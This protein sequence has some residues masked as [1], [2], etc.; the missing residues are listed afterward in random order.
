MPWGSLVLVPGLPQ[1]QLRSVAR[2]TPDEL[3]AYFGTGSNGNFGS[4]ADTDALFVATRSGVASAFGSETKLTGVNGSDGMSTPSISADGNTLYYTWGE[5]PNHPATGT[6]RDIYVA[7]RTGSASEFGSGSAINI[8]VV[9]SEENYAYIASD[10]TLWYEAKPA[11][12]GT[13][14][15]I[16]SAPPAGSGAFATPSEFPLDAPMM[17]NTY[18]VVSSDLRHVYF[19]RGGLIY[20][21]SRGSAGD[22]FSSA[23]GIDELNNDYCLMTPCRPTWISPDNCRLYVGV[24]SMGSA[25]TM[26][27]SSKPAN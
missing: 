22:T 7:T 21:A 24:G 15:S 12:S 2:F 20:I 9:G 23:T 18:P 1:N 27:V 26:Y 8:D 5:P 6:G 4:S 10:G 16:Y 11:G 19:Q 13:Y 14:R 3:T 25:L 17:P